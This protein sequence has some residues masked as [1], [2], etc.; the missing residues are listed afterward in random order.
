MDK[1]SKAILQ[2]VIN[3][4]EGISHFCSIADEW[5]N[6]SDTPLSRL[7][8]AVNASPDDVKAAVAYLE[9]KNFVQYRSLKSKTGSQKIAFHLTHLGL[10]YKEFKFIE[11]RDRWKERIV[12]FVSGVLVTVFGGLI[13]EWLIK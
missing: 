7:V 4:G 3:T 12:G 5:D 1:L 13:L 9:R 10:H 2:Y 6:E 8:E 11:T